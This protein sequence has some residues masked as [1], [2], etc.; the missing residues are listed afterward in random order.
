MEQIITLKELLA[1]KRDDFNVL[2]WKSSSIKYNVRGLC[3]FLRD[4]FISIRAVDEEED[5]I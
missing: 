5:E 4:R 3:I 1:I 2:S